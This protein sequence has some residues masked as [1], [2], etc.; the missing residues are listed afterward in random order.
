MPPFHYSPGLKKGLV[1]QEVP[2][3]LS[4]WRDRVP[5][6]IESFHRPLYRGE[7]D[8]H[9]LYRDP[10]AEGTRTSS[11]LHKPD[12]GELQTRKHD[13]RSGRFY[14]LYHHLGV[15]LTGSGKQSKVRGRAVDV[16]C[17]RDWV[18]DQFQAGRCSGRRLPMPPRD[19]SQ[20]NPIRAA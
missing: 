12:V 6:W 2:S 10:V 7:A 11:I 4:P 8:R 5:G 17:E 15:G 1:S 9:A 19:A 20:F 16:F 14:E 18:E 13:V 3:R